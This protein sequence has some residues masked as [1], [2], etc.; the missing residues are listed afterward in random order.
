M[1][2]CMVD[3]CNLM[4]EVMSIPPN[5]EVLL[6]HGGGHAMFAAVP[7]NL[8]GEMGAPADF[9]G[10]GFWSK[11]AAG[12][13]SKYC[14]VRHTAETSSLNDS[15]YPD[16]AD[17]KFSEGA[18]YVHM[19]AN[20]T[21]N[22]LEFHED[23]SLPEGAPPL[24][25]DFTSTLLSRPVDFTK[26]GVVYASTGKNLGP[27]GLVVAVVRKDL[28]GDGELPITPGILSFKASASSTPIANLWNT[29]NVFGI[30]ALQLVLE[31][32]K[33]NGGVEEMQRRARRRAGAL[34]DLID[35]SEGFYTNDVDPKFRSLMT[36]PL[37]IKGGDKELERRFIEESSPAS[38][39]NLV[40]HPLFGGLRVTV[41]NQLPDEAVDIL[42]CFMREF[43]RR[44][45]S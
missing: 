33:A 17:W 20:E 22:G 32:L 29:P 16:V 14:T 39:Y 19:T 21:I 4:R 26:Y 1:Q 10:D 11:R 45:V 13:A 30:R 41:Y 24:V 38:I 44:A 28:I 3:T 9:I 5:Y 37:R 2:T 36:I 12:E 42:L 43:Q 18:K 31:D 35:A 23:P 34:Y 8:A 25:A 27:S 15:R 40:G 7:L 6:M